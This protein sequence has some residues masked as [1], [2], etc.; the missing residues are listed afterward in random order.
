MNRHYS[1]V[2]ATE[3][4]L[5]LIPCLNLIVT[6]DLYLYRTC[7]DNKDK[8]FAD[9]SIPQEKTDAQINAEL[10]ISEEEE[11]LNVQPIFKGVEP[12]KLAGLYIIVTSDCV[13]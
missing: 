6:A 3:F 1:E 2:S 10:G 5:Y 13:S 12:S 9:C 11:C 7:K 4:M 8:A